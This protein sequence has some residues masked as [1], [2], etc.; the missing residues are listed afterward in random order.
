MQMDALDIKTFSDDVRNRV[1]PKTRDIMDRIAEMTG[2]AHGTVA[3]F[4]HVFDLTP[5]GDLRHLH[6][7]YNRRPPDTYF[8]RIAAI[9]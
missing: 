1:S 5:N 4:D 9:S 2:H 6:N 7:Q 3:K 8:L